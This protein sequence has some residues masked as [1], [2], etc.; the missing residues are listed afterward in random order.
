[1]SLKTVSIYISICRISIIFFV[2]INGL[3]D[4][5]HADALCDVCE[6]GLQGEIDQPLPAPHEA[7]IA[8]TQQSLGAHISSIASF[9]YPS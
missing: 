4:S 8:S 2:Q 6:P 5:W 7:S 9:P 3:S 1:M